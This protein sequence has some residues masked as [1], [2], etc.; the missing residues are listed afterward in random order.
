MRVKVDLRFVNG[1]DMDAAFWFRLARS[2]SLAAIVGQLFLFVVVFAPDRSDVI[3]EQVVESEG[4]RHHDAR[5]DNVGTSRRLPNSR[6]E[7][8]DGDRRRYRVGRFES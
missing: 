7:F 6:N 4:L 1:A 5:I 8:R 3:D 2:Y